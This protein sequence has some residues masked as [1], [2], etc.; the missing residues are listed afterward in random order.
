MIEDRE[1]SRHKGRP[2]ELFLFRG[3]EPSLEAL[4]K[5]ITISPGL[6]EFGYGTT[7]VT[8][9]VEGLT[10]KFT[11]EVWGYQTLE[12]ELVLEGIVSQVDNGLVEA[13]LQFDYVEPVVETTA[14]YTVKFYGAG[15]YPSNLIETWTI[16]IPFIPGELSRD[17]YYNVPIGTRSL[18]ISGTNTEPFND[19]A[20]YLIL[21]TYT[22]EVVQ[23]E[24]NRVAKQPVTDFVAAIED[25]LVCAPNLSHVSLIAAWHGTDLRAGHC[26]IIPKVEDS[27][28]VTQPYSWQVGPVVR[29]TA[30]VVSQISNKPAMGGA[31]SDR[32][33]FEA[34]TFLKSKGLQVT[35]YPVIAMD[36]PGANTLPSPYG[37]TGQPGYPWRGRI[38]CY[39]A[40]GEPETVDQTE[41]AETQIAAF[42]GATTATHF[43]W[44]GSGQHVAYS[45]PGGEWSLRRFILHMATIAVAAGAD[46]FIIGSELVGLTQVRSDASTFPAVSQLLSLLT[47]VRTKVG[48][49]VKVSYAAHW[50]EYHSYKPTDESG[51]ILFPLDDLWSDENIDYIG[52]NNYTPLGDWRDGSHADR[53]AGFISE[54]QKNYIQSNMEAGEHF[55][56]RYL[57]DEDR[58]D[59]VRTPIEDV[60]YAENWIFRLKDFRNWWSSEHF[61]R[62]AGVKESTKSS[63]VPESKIIA[64][65]ENGIPAINRATNDP[66]AY[67]DPKSSES[68]VPHFSN[69]RPDASIQRSGL[70]AQL[71][72]WRS[73]AGSMLDL[74]RLSIHTWDARPYPTFPD[75]KEI[76]YDASLWLKGYHLSGRLRPGLGFEAGSFGPYAFCNGEEPI[77]RDGIIY[78]PFPISIS[79]ITSSGNLDKSD[80]TVS[81]ARESVMESEFIGFP[82]SQI[83]NLIVFHGHIDDEPTLFNFPAAWVGRVGAPAFDE[84]KISF[85]CVP[86]STSIQRPGLRRNYQLSC[87]HALF[88]PQCRASKNDATVGR[89]VSDILGTTITFETPLPLDS[90]KY[91]GGLVEW[92]V[93]GRSAIRTIISVNA[94][95]TSLTIRG[96]LRDLII[97]ATVKITFGCNRLQ[98]DCFELHNNILNFGGQP[99]IPLENPLSQKNIFY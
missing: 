14:N 15:G 6:T 37:G 25:L 93:S 59:Q 95:K 54:Y 82:V 39:P 32:T 35:L 22:T 75:F 71:M 30:Q 84:E 62:I 91:R 21:R 70:E 42:F 99:L 41:D 65:T 12:R 88:G 73:N 38:T 96:N 28:T 24:L 69:E 80:I 5:S 47:E 77:T 44:N 76:F 45:G 49:D 85:N 56:W 43:S 13:K 29:S 94:E 51:D 3:T 16:N 33:L 17:F 74:E 60:A 89:V 79:D 61:A 98:S 50:T 31:P 55:D 92:S 46:D 10:D 97:G 11:Q 83:I 7:P 20:G 67:Y 81:L 26:K 27:T 9:Q 68:R 53:E 18:V 63:W 19:S 23:R 52:I 66:N 90:T 57:T 86:V 48:S 87:P 34:I 4:I 2:I 78:Q 1:Q 64:F 36:I 8:G 72:Y 40:P 58:A